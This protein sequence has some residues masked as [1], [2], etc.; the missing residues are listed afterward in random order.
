[1]GTEVQLVQ[2][3]HLS[4]SW[5]L[6]C[7]ELLGNRSA[8]HWSD[9]ATSFLFPMYISIGS[10]P[11]YTRVQSDFYCLHFSLSTRRDRSLY[12]TRQQGY[13]MHAPACVLH[14]TM[15]MVNLPFSVLCDTLLQAGQIFLFL[16][17]PFLFATT[18]PFHISQ[19]QQTLQEFAKC[20]DT[21]KVGYKRPNCPLHR[22]HSMLTGSRQELQ[23]TAYT[24][25]K[26]VLSYQIDVNATHLVYIYP[27]QYPWLN[28]GDAVQTEMP[29]TELLAI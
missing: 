12:F 23:K 22:S 29:C 2:S 4:W 28:C 5:G 11:L 20:K 9:G 21:R 13:V 27:A 24:N 25:L 1:M 10:L 16:R 7:G 17:K 26:V 18:G 3:F 19:V 15:L 14:E 8:E 6:H